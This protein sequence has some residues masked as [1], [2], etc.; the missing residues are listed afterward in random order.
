VGP[1]DFREHVKNETRALETA[2]IVEAL[3]AH[4]GNQTAAAKALNLPVR[5]LTHKMKELG[6]K[7]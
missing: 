6:I 4:G 3:R 7:R 2:L 5:T 1:R